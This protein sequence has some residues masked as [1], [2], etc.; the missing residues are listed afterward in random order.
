[1]RLTKRSNISMRVL[2]FCGINDGRLVTKS[3]IAEACNTSE[4]H[5]AQVIN[6]L[7]QLGFLHTQRGRNGGMRLSRPMSEIMVGDVFRAIESGVPITE[8]FDAEE[9]TCPL[10]DVCRL[11]DVIARATE[12]FY[13]SMDD[14]TLADLVCENDGLNAL[15]TVPISCPRAVA[16]A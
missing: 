5:L 7:S 14:V 4:N 11:R 15:L 8:C 3:E 6:R 9:N 13:A 2:M 1:M 12:A 10:I 16:D